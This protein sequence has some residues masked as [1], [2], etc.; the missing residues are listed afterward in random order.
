MGFHGYHTVIAKNI[1]QKKASGELS[2][3][4]QIAISYRGEGEAKGKRSAAKLYN[5]QLIPVT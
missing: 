5:M 2:R 4:A 3:G 1:A